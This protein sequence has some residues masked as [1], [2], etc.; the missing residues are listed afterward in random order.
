[1]LIKY[2]RYFFSELFLFKFN[3]L[4]VLFQTL[5]ILLTIFLLFRMVD[6]LKCVITPLILN[7]HVFIHFMLFLLV[8]C[9]IVYLSIFHTNY[10]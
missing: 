10:H 6:Q 7:Y 9:F 3:N 4:F 2:S 8:F 5:I 1:M